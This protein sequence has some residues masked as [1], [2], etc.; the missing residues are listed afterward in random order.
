MYEVTENSTQFGNDT[1]HGYST[2]HRYPHPE[3]DESIT[4]V[5]A[6]LVRELYPTGRAWVMPEKGV[7]ENLHKALNV[8]FLRLIDDCRSTINSTFPDN[9][10]FTAEDAALWE[11]RLG[12]FINP[13]VDLE[14][15]K[16]AI[17][18]KMA[19]PSNVKARQHP[20]FIQHQLQ[21][22]GFDVYIHENIFYEDAPVL[23][24]E[25]SVLVYKTP[26]EIS[27]ISLESVQHGEPTQ[28][29][30]QHGAVGFDVIANHI[31]DETYGIGE[32]NL[33]AS[34]FIGGQEL[35]QMA[36]VPENRKR[37]FKEL[38]LKLKPAHT[39]AFSFINYV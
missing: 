14:L 35:G 11:Y 8:S 2:P 12:L 37:E 34:F 33:W 4:S 13:S 39:V 32:G 36:E 10:N 9:E 22:A 1:P 26:S 18:R 27:E 3:G 7:F 31:S 25:V 23:S 24:D 38:V 16:M 21:I 15:R 5:F 20:L 28:H 6:G 17:Q 19:Y 29:G 30:A